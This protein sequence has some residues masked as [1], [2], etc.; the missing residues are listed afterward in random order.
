L[1]LLLLLMTRLP[2]RLLVCLMLRLLL[3]AVGLP[4]LLILLPVRLLPI[5]LA[6]PLFL[7]QVRLPLICRTLLVLLILL[8]V[9]LI[10]TRLISAIL[11]LRR[12][13]LLKVALLLV[14]P[15]DLVL[16]A[17]VLLL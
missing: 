10:A 4:L 7:L 14:R 11:G 16:L 5:F 13:P 2:Q 6:H 1:T 3:F 17:I 12:L 8:P 15:H 9:A